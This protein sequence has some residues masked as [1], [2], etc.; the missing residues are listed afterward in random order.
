MANIARSRYALLVIFGTQGWCF[1][2]LLSQVPVLRDRFH[3]SDLALGFVLAVV[4]FVAG[5]GSLTAGRLV[6]RVGT[7][8]VLRLAT[9]VT[10]AALVGIGTVGVL[11][12]L[13]AVLVV[14]GFALGAVDTTMNTFGVALQRIAGRGLMSRF[15]A[16]YSLGSILGSLLAAFA[17]ARGAPLGML[18]LLVGLFGSAACAVAGRALD[19]SATNGPG[20]APADSTVP[21]LWR[22]LAVIGAVT[23]SLFL[24]DSAVSNWSATYLRSALMASEHIGALAYTAYMAGTLLG[25][26]VGDT[27]TDRCGAAFV[28]RAGSL[29]AALGTILVVVATTPAAAL[30]G[31]A[32]AGF[33]LSVVVPQ[34]F[35]AAANAVPERPAAAVSRINLCV[36]AGF[37]LGA[38]T[39]GTIAAVWSLRAA[40]AAVVVVIV[41]I[42]V[43]APGLGPATTRTPRR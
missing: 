20:D 16:A 32:V 3:L 1:A 26:S 19:P 7:V 2:T 27:A 6:H 8:P 25:R 35:V 30:A 14:L 28:V 43:A 13:L 4:P 34:A 23:V 33:G 15:H 24:V 9:L 11:A 42:T 37:V 17:T 22:R 31:F 29:I 40:F 18:F 12:A 39:I 5:V 38:P 10:C 36:Y 41:G 21:H